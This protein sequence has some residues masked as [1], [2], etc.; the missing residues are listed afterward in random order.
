MGV[1]SWAGAVLVAVALGTSACSS[2]EQA[3]PPPPTPIGDGPL[4]LTDPCTLLPASA[5]SVAGLRRVTPT[6]G[7]GYR[8]C[9]F[10]HGPQGSAPDYSVSVGIIASGEFPSTQDSTLFVRDTT[11]PAGR[12]GTRLRYT[13]VP[14]CQYVADTAPKE[15]ISVMVTGAA[16]GAEQACQVLDSLAAE[17]VKALPAGV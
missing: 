17:V 5:A 2:D 16:G 14:A 8:D 12:Q 13:A 15:R 11:A 1:R 9:Q 4:R 6:G 7:T 3:A 10:E